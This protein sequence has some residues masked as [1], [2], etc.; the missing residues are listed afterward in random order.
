MDKLDL[1]D[2]YEKMY[3]HEID[4]RDKLSQ[5]LQ[6]TL[7]ILVVLFGFLGYM[8]ESASYTLGNI[9]AYMFWILFVLATISIFV[10]VYWF[11]RSWYGWEYEFLAPA[12]DWE[13][14]RRQ[15]AKT[16]EEFTE[17][18][19]LVRQYMNNAIMKHLV[20]CSSEFTRINDTRS[21][22]LHNA[23][24]FI[25]IGI[26]VAFLAFIPFWVGLTAQANNGQAGIAN[27]VQPLVRGDSCMHISA[28]DRRQPPPSTSA[29]KEA[30][31][32]RGW[33]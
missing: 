10:A 21:L 30:D 6:I 1:F 4:M 26:V 31:S 28:S 20:D 7:A 27:K 13:A 19:R 22:K 18:D 16:Y 12:D 15:L 5:R 24:T 14:Y 25:I 33:S 11:V 9:F 17:C 29:S 3:F 32:K 8:L 2:L 23:N